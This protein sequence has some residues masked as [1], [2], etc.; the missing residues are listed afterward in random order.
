MCQQAAFGNVSADEQNADVKMTITKL[1]VNDQTL[2]LSWKIVNHS[3][4]DVWI[5]DSVSVFSATD[6][7]VYLSEDEQSLLIRRRLDVPTAW[8][9]GQC[10]DGRYVLLRS[11]QERIESVSLAV[12]V[13]PWRLYAD[14]L[15]LPNSDHARR[16]VLEIGFYDEDLPKLIRDILEMAK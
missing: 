16:L 3:D 11:G 8:V 10:P 4:H 1:K 9:W 7:E 14:G 12:P 13:G 15:A 5:C 6:F 2:E